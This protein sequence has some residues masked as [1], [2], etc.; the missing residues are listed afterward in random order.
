MDPEELGTWSYPADD[1]SDW[2]GDRYDKDVAS[3]DCVLVNSDPDSDG[4]ETIEI[5]VT[6]GYP[7]YYGSI[8]FDI[9]NVGT[10]PV[11]VG[12]ITLVEISKGESVKSVDVDLVAGNTVYIDYEQGTVSLTQNVNGADTDDF[13]LH[14]GN[15]TIPTQID[16]G[17]KAW[18]A[19]TIHVEQGAEENQSYDFTIEIICAQ[20]NEY[21]W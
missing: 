14:L 3:I 18:G 12:N 16:K 5:T 10:V 8:A 4:D 6:D 13:S 20:W 9:E 7:S 2:T 1:P 19:I 17:D 21:P 11:M 15:L